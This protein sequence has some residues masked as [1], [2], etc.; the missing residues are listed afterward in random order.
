MP[1]H[2]EMI[3]TETGNF[4]VLAGDRFA[5]GLC[6]DEALGVIAA[7]L[8]C[9]TQAPPYLRTYSEWSVWHARYDR[10]FSQP[11]ALLAWNG[12]AH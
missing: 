2:V 1:L 9:G 10:D 12:C 11:V 5:S 6:R 3:E 4:T 7:L 8:F